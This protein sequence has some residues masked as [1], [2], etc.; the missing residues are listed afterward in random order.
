MGIGRVKWEKRSQTTIDWKAVGQRLKHLRADLS[1]AEF[2][3]RI[4]ISQG[5]LSHL[6]RGEKEIGPEILLRISQYSGKSME[7]ILT[8]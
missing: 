4:G 5:Y 8:G 3:T 7:W 1:Q 6:E 2:A